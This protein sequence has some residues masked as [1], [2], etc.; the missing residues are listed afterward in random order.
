[1]TKIY[2]FHINTHFTA[3]KQLPGLHK[4]AV[5]VSAQTLPGHTLGRVLGTANIT[6][7]PG[8][9]VET[10]LLRCGLDG[11]KN[12][13]APEHMYNLNDQAQVFASVN[14]IANNQYQLKL[15][16]SSFV[17]NSVNIPAFTCEAL[18]RL[19][20]APFIQ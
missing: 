6:V 3:L 17:D 15:V 4:G 14:Q 2:N 9:Y 5:T 12:Y 16:A 8:I 1:M 7:P 20:I 10:P 13:L 19:A 11:N 18:L